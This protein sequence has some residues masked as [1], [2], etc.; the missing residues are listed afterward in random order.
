MLVM[1]ALHLGPGPGAG[2]AVGLLMLTGLYGWQQALGHGRAMG[3]TPTARVASA[4]QGYV[5]LRGTGYPLNGSPLLSPFNGLPVLWYRVITERRE[6]DKWVHESTDESDASFLLD[7]GSGSVAIDPEG[8]RIVARRKEVHLRGEHRITQWCLLRHDPIYVLGEFITLGSISPDHD[9]AAATRELLAH[10]KQDH[11]SLLARFDTN[12]DGEISL[13]EWEQARATARQE[14]TALRDQALAAPEAHVVRK[15]ADRR[16]Y[17]I[18]DLDPDR[19]MRRFRL[20]A[21]YHLTLF[22]GGAAG[23]AWLSSRGYLG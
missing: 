5:E 4:A 19:L 23:L 9:V 11:P 18:S 15:P 21:A 10:W 14:V 1:A 22:L 7:D 16:L 8:A 6:R 2:F 17:L 3:D 13:E 20:W 12:K